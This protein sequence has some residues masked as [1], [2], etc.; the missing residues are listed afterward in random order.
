[1]P[2][3]DTPEWTGEE[4][5]PYRVLRR[6]GMG[7]MAETFEAVRFGPGG[8]SQRVCLKLVLPFYRNDP[9]FIRLFEREARLAARLRHSNIVGI[10]DF[11]NVDGTPYIA[12]ELVD[13]VDLQA[14]LKVQPGRRLPPEFIE[15]MALELAQGLAH[16]HN[17]AGI[18]GGGKTS[19]VRGIAH[20]DLSP[21]NVMLSVEGE[22][23]LT[24][25][26]VAKA[27][28]GT[29]RKQSDVKGKV[30]YMSPEQLRNEMVD[31]R[32]DLFSLGVLVYESLAGQR[33]YDGGSDPATIL[34]IL[35]GNRPPLRESVPDAPEGLCRVIDSLIEP[36]KEKRPVSAV[37]LV[38]QLD[39]FAPSPRVR[40]E[41]GKMV[42][43]LR[44]KPG[45]NEEGLLDSYRSQGRLVST[46]PPPVSGRSA[47]SAST[48]PRTAGHR[49]SSKHQKIHFCRTPDDVGLAWAELGEGPPI[50]KAGNWC[51]HLELDRSTLSWHHIV[52]SLSR[53]HRLVRYDA[54]GNGLSDH[55]VPEVNFERWVSDL[56]TVI[57]AAG[58]DR[59]PL[60]GLSQGAAVAAAYAA[61]HPE[62]VSALVLICGLVRG[63]RVKGLPQVT[64]HFEALLSLVEAGWGQD[65]PAFRQIFTTAFFPDASKEELDGF[66]E[67]QRRSATPQN[68]VKMLSTIGDIDL[69]SEVSQ[70]RAPTLVVHGRNDLVIPFSDGKELAA[71][72]PGARFV[73]LETKSHI[74][75]AN[76]PAWR[77]MEYEIQG[78]LDT[79]P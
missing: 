70:V 39:E 51:S 8:F 59:F 36:D 57:D 75:L 3:A 30:P 61:R 31:G 16:A 22:I 17:P 20:R 9:D 47:T 67:L 11:G 18:S 71:G 53:E 32:A 5:G 44:S 63:W 29:N 12:L 38:E 64:R 68:A 7:G 37:A 10:I 40:R 58:L 13:G 77:R 19:E 28:D 27:M 60:I 2:E 74:P 26:G 65:N 15:L 48:A 69:R 62:R 76:D 25:F 23:L 45:E 52:E 50:V 4:F 24:D 56:G 66:N 21:S 1:M 42:S 14:L 6:L 43:K 78:F 55:D 34:L 49:E 35:Q 79:H 73:P 72:I 41:L 54:R 46:R 33:P